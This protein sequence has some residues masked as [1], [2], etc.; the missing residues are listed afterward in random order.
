VTYTFDVAISD[1]GVNIKKDRVSVTET[2]SFNGMELVLDKASYN[3][4]TGNLE[5]SATLTK[6]GKLIFSESLSA[7]GNV[8]LEKEDFTAKNINVNVNLIDRMQIKGSCPDA[9]SLAEI[10]LNSEPQSEKDW[11]RIVNNANTKFDL[12]VYFDGGNTVQAVINLEPRWDSGE[13]GNDYWCEP[14]IEFNDG[15][16]YLFYEYFTED[17]FK[18]V[19]ND[20]ESFVEKYENLLERYFGFIY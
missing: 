1:G 8:D 20:A 2:L 10:F 14:A 18:D 4:S 15:S 5:A 13:W 7:E 3:A 12:N 9:R 16:R 11:E 6:D 17:S 19:I